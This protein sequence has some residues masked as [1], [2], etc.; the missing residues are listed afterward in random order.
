MKKFLLL[1]VLAA[2][3]AAVARS[4]VGRELERDVWAEFADDLA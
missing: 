2:I 3:A 1:I 4:L